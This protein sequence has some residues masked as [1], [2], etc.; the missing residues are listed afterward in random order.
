MS[1]LG[2]ETGLS[3]RQVGQGFHGEGLDLAPIVEVG[4][5]DREGLAFSSSSGLLR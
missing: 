4:D 2:T 5:E 1:H 3:L